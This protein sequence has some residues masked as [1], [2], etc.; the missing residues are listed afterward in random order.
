MPVRAVCILGEAETELVVGAPEDVAEARAP[1]FD[2][3]I[4][5]PNGSLVFHD[6]D[7]TELVVYPTP[8]PETRI[9]IWTDG[10]MLPERVV[11][12]VG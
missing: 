5:T 7:L 6:A 4:P 1:Q 11:V 12:A 9:R 10:L 2:C 8:T 3:T